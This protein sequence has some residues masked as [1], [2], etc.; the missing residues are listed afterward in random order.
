MC[1]YRGPDTLALVR[2]LLNVVAADCKTDG[3]VR[4]PS[5]FLP[6]CP[7]CGLRRASMAAGGLVFYPTLCWA[8]ENKVPSINIKLKA[9]SIMNN[10]GK[11]KKK[12]SAEMGRRKGQG[13][14]AV[15]PRE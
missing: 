11:G 10:R 12:L 5:R 13:I 8:H 2:T 3:P 14:E 9:F 1:V 7:Y 6:Q 4:L 15:C